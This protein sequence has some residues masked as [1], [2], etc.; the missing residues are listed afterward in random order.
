M[1]TIK[2]SPVQSADP[3]NSWKDIRPAQQFDAVNKQAFKK[4]KQDEQVQR[5]QEAA[6]KLNYKRFKPSPAENEE[7]K[8]KAQVFRFLMKI[9]NLLGKDAFA[10]FKQTFREYKTNPVC[11]VD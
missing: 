10:K 8:E 4:R 9:E 3:V 7:E 1:G 5:K 6:F 11:T 2:K